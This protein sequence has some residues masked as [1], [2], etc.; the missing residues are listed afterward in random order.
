MGA[1][2]SSAKAAAEAPM[3]TWSL[4]QSHNIG[5]ALGEF[6]GKEMIL[7]RDAV[8]GAQAALS[9]LTQGEVACESGVCIVFS[10]EQGEYFLLWRSDVKAA[11][12]EKYSFTDSPGEAPTE[13]EPEAPAEPEPLMPTPV[14]PH[15]APSCITANIIG[16]DEPDDK[17]VTYFKVSVTSPQAVYLV[18]R[19][20]NDFCDLKGHLGA[21]C[22]QEFPRKTVRACTGDRLD[23]RRAQLELWLQGILPDQSVDDL[24]LHWAN[25]LKLEAAQATMGTWSM[26]QSHTIGTTL[27]E[28]ED[29]EMILERSDVKDVQDALRALAHGEVACESGVCIVL[30]EA[31]GEYFLLFRSDV[32]AAVYEKYNLCD[33]PNELGAAA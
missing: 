15:A 18:K 5:T 30:S 13:P 16:W 21:D 27:G 22:S 24:P 20:Y 1:K 28:F 6:E 3:G 32:K 26:T 14:V 2:Q 7:D 11:L 10:E 33:S 4:T 25:F 12:Y 9:A 17:G 23:A 29:K 19:R 31:K 8:K